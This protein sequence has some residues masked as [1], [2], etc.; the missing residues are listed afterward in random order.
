MIQPVELPLPKEVA[1][2]IPGPW[3]S[4]KLKTG[5]F[6]IFCVYVYGSLENFV[7]CCLESFNNSNLR[8]SSCFNLQCGSAST[9]KIMQNLPCSHANTNI[10]LWKKK[11][12]LLIFP[13]PRRR[14]RRQVLPRRGAG[15]QGLAPPSR[16]RATEEGAGVSCRRRRRGSEIW[17]WPV[18]GR[19]FYAGGAS[20]GRP[21]SLAG[22]WPAT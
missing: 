20:A 1:L 5:T 6:G 21:R 17:P 12:L 3:F 22:V 2:E 9:C 15:G 16:E 19:F 14:A 11:T 7:S 10:F 4:G 8:C 13:G 18:R